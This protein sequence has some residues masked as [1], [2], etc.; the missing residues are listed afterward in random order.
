MEGSKV[1]EDNLQSS[2]TTY[3]LSLTILITRI[4]T[5]VEN[6]LKVTYWSG[7]LARRVHFAFMFSLTPELPA[8]IVSQ[9]E[10]E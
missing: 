5:F 8:S 2:G 7:L 4:A 10:A 1:V 9:F 3:L 6:T